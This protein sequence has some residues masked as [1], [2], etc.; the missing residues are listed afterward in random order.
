[1]GG[2]YQKAS[3]Q[4]RTSGSHARIS[5]NLWGRNPGIAMPTAS[6]RNM[7]RHPK[8]VLSCLHICASAQLLRR[9][10]LGQR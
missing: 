4:V 6:G 9:D 7:Q 2:L 10:D 8:H 5:R 1:M 3:G